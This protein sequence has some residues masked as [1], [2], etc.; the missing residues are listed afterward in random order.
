MYN[1]KISISTKIVSFAFIDPPIVELNGGG[2]INENEKLK[3][4]CNVTAYPTIDYYRWYK[5]NKKLNTSFLASSIIIEKVSKEDAGIYA[6]M[7]KNTLKYPNGSSVEKFN[8]TQTRV[9]V[10]CKKNFRFFFSFLLY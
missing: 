2:L 1:Q 5:N 3:L 6:C 10:H 8:K 7:V 4:I 9:I